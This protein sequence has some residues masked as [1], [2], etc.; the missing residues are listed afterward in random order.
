MILVVDPNAGP[1]F[2]GALFRVNPSNGSRV[3]ISSFDDPSQ[4]LRGSDPQGVSVYTVKCGGL[5]ATRIGNSFD[6]T[7]NGTSGRDIIHG[8]GGNDTIYGLGGDDV[9]CGG[10]GDDTLSGGGGNDR[11]FGDAGRD[12]LNGGTGTDTCNGGA[13]NDTATGC[14]TTL[15]VP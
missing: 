12:K 8:L 4:G 3:L 6:N 15:S 2:A 10:A 14:E 7:I 1:I 5:N 13:H 9:L 11:L